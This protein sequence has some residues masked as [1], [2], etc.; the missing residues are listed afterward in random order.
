VILILA[1]TLGGGVAAVA[2]IAAVWGHHHARAHDKSR[3]Q[4]ADARA[5]SHRA[6]LTT[7]AT[8]RDHASTADQLGNPLGGEITHLIDHFHRAPSHE[9][10]TPR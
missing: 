1:I 10:D 2:V 9:K 4:D 6:A 5:A 8:I 7:L 3:L